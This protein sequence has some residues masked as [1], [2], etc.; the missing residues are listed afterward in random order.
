MTMVTE[1][2][3]GQNGATLLTKKE[4]IEDTIQMVSDLEGIESAISIYEQMESMELWQLEEI[5]KHY[6]TILYGVD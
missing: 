5:Q 4:I 1:Q 6:E 3:T 2:A